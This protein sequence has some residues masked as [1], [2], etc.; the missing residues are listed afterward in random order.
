MDKNNVLPPP[1]LLTANLINSWK[2]QGVLNTCS[3]GKSPMS[4]PPSPPV[5]TPK[6]RKFIPN[7]MPLKN[8]FEC[9]DTNSNQV[10][11]YI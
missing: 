5:T 11:I 10:Y 4:N 3:A 7:K 2:Q 6:R 8:N 1:Q 9:S